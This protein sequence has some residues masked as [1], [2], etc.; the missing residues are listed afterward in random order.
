MVIS[1]KIFSLSALVFALIFISCGTVSGGNN[2]FVPVDYSEERILDIEIDLVKK[3][4]EENKIKALWRAKLL[5]DKL[6]ENDK[7][8]AFFEEMAQLCM[9]GYQNSLNEKLYFAALE[10]YLSL[11]AIGYSGLKSV[12]M[13]K[14]ELTRLAY[15]NV[16]GS[17][18]S[19]APNASV[20]DMIKGTV[21]VFVDKGIK[22]QRG[23]GYADAVLGSGFFISKD[24]YIVTNHHVISDM[25]DKKYE[26]F[27]RLYIKLAEDP[28]TRIPAKVVGYDKTLDLALLKCEIDAPYVFALGS[29]SDLSVGDKVYAIGSPLG[30][31]KTL[32][33]GII[34]STD[35]QLFT[36]GTV[37]QVDA[38]INSGNSGGPLID[39][40]GR[41]QA[42]VFAGVQNFQGLNFAIPVEYLKNELPFLFYG[43]E[44]EHPWIASYGKTKRLPG[45][46]AE[47]EGVSV[48]YVLPGGS[49][50]RAGISEGSVIV[51]V[52]GEPVR[53][54]YDL[55]LAFMKQPSGVI[56]K[57]GV[58]SAE[59]EKSEKILY[60]EKRP[61]S[62]GY[63]FYK[64][65]SLENAFYPMFGMKMVR[66]SPSNK[67]KY[68]IE[69]IIKGSVADE[70]GFSENDPIELLGI[71]FSPEKEAA[72]IKLYAKKRKNGYLDVSL[73]FSAALDSP[74]YF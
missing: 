31:E 2:I 16:P 48:F 32:T 26:G 49:A 35:R 57:V 29:S 23:I 68:S 72:Y 13:S 28:D 12:S 22:I 25:V 24:G 14:Q 6:P 7:T 65:D 18:V 10:Y 74:Y 59:N 42:V 66:V 17:S 60:L 1:N 55:Q 40:K 70:T 52:N 44:R 5:Y 3:L 11:D 51:S 58:L 63:E 73:G 36:A 33:S 61:S 4:S 45:S 53:S 43:G 21:T 46:G 50:D 62:P 19:S 34:S 54:L 41:V 8:A 64:H 38:A 27:S 69:K 20:S 67:K 39:Q 56:I 47:N 15:Q 37:F 71:D 9:D 30:L